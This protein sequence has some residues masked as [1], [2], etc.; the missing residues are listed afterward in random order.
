MATSVRLWIITFG[1]KTFQTPR[2]IARV[3]ANVWPNV[4]KKANVIQAITAKRYQA[5]HSF[6]FF[7]FIIIKIAAVAIKT[8]NRMYMKEKD[9]SIGGLSISNGSS[10]NVTLSSTISGEMYWL[11][12]ARPINCVKKK[13]MIRDI[14]MKRVCFICGCGR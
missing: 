9:S 4:L 14:V 11:I 2:I 3:T 12:T 6:N 7:H 1:L 13:N 10:V 5:F 8:A